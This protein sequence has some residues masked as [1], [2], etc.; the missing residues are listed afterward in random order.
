MQSPFGRWESID[1][2][3]RSDL[4]GHEFN[5]GFKL[6]CILYLL[7]EYFKCFF[8]KGPYPSDFDLWVWGAARV[9]GVLKASR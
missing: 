5:T 4:I 1:K 6:G 9:P 7:E 2:V 8:F 3:R